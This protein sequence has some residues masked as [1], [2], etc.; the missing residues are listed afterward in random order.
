MDGASGK[1]GLFVSWLFRMGGWM[2]WMEW[3]EWKDQRV[4]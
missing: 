3:M 2:E 4:F 1:G